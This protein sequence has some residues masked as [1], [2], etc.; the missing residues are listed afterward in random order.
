MAGPGGRRGGRD[1]GPGRPRCRSRG[2]RGGPVA[3]PRSPSPAPSPSSQE[4]RCFEFLLR[5]D[6]DPLGI[7]RLPGKFVEF[8]H[9]VEP[10]QFVVTSPGR[11]PISVRICASPWINR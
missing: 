5:I 2:R 9:G 6:D 3:A 1:H 8:V 11:V 7:K 4:E 10:A